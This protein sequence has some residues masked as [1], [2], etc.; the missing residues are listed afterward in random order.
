MGYQ[1]VF[2]ARTRV[3]AGQ[4]SYP[5]G[6]THEERKIKMAAVCCIRETGYLICLKRNF[7]LPEA[8]SARKFLVNS[9]YGRKSASGA[10]C[11]ARARGSRL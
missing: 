1:N 6:P 8:V 7:R 5:R 11:S 9:I 4:T 10:Q 2:N 3:H